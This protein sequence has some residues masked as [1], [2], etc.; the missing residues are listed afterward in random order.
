MLVCTKPLKPWH[1]K[2]SGK[3]RPISH[4][5]RVFIQQVQKCLLPN[6]MPGSSRD[7]G[8]SLLSSV[9]NETSSMLQPL[10]LARVVAWL[11]FFHNLV[12]ICS[13]LLSL[14]TRSY[15]VDV[16]PLG[17]RITEPPPPACAPR[18]RN[19]SVVPSSKHLIINLVQQ[20]FIL[21][22]LP[23]KRNPTPY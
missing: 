12:Y 16:A 11:W 9:Q 5:G 19:R 20:G 22:K 8:S 14:R 1:Q 21:L 2:N 3:N 13:E 10:L 17:A 23:G 6:Q 18:T 4:L 7:M 15:N